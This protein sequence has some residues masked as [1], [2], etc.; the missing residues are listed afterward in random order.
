VGAVIDNKHL[1]WLFHL[2]KT[3]TN[4]CFQIASHII[5]GDHDRDTRITDCS[6]VW[7]LHFMQITTLLYGVRKCIRVAGFEKVFFPIP[8]ITSG[9]E[10]P[11]WE[12][13]FFERQL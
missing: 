2:Q 8:S 3:R 12:Q 1:I 10:D 11:G 7:Y 9:C 5:V 13:C 4:S 6:L